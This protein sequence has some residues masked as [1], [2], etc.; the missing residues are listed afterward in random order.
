M[1]YITFTISSCRILFCLTDGSNP[2]NIIVADVKI[3][4]AVAVVAVVG[5]EEDVIAV[6]V[7]LGVDDGVIVTEAAVKVVVLVVDVDVVGVVEDRGV[8]VVVTVVVAV[9]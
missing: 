6:V 7:V 2:S 5:V 1:L 4:D 9:V 3:V 8:G